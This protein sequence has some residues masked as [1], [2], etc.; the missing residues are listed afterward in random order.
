MVL[1]FEYHAMASSLCIRVYSCNMSRLFSIIQRVYLLGQN[2]W[3]KKKRFRTSDVIF[4]STTEY[5]V[6]IPDFSEL[7]STLLMSTLIY[8]PRK[9]WIGLPLRSAQ[10][11]WKWLAHLSIRCEYRVGLTF[12]SMQ[13]MHNDL[14]PPPHHLATPFSHMTL[15][16]RRQHTGA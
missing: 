11:R 2:A 16:L 7:I 15:L 10:M 1:H 14:C 5:F 4:K 3:K 12:T 13:Q 6:K 9:H 8:V